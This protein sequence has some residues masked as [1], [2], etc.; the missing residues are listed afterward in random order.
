[1]WATRGAVGLIR[2]YQ[3]TLSRLLPNVCRFTPSC[4]Q[5]AVEAFQRHG[6]FRGLRLALARLARCHPWSPGG[7]DPVPARKTVTGASPDHTKEV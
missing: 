1:M 2:L 5:Y 7:S 4:S 3:R 6:F